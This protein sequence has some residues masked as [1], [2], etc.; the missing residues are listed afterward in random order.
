MIYRRLVRP[1]LFRAYGGDAER[2]HEQT[3][4]SLRTVGQL[5]PVR[6][7]TGALL[8]RH[9][10]PVTVAGIDFPSPVGVAAGLDKNGVAVRSWAA[11]GFGFAELGTVTARPSPAT[12]GP[13]CSG[14]PGAGRSSTGWASTTP[15]RR[16]WP[17]GWRRRVWP[18]A[19]GRW[20]CRSA[21]PSASRR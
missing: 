5:A 16:R 3:L 4:T 21:S 12:T 1:L 7:A 17:G 15:V 10:R 20:A 19:T 13:G 14:C 18:A 11:L 2:V 9:R 8:A 6:A